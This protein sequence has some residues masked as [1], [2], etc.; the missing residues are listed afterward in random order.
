MIFTLKVCSENIMRVRQWILYLHIQIRNKNVTVVDFTQS[1][2]GIN[3]FFP[4]EKQDSRFCL[5]LDKRVISEI[6]RLVKE[7]GVKNCSEMKKHIEIWRKKN[8]SNVSSK[9]HR[10]NPTAAD[11]RN[12]I[13]LALC[14]RFASFLN[15]LLLIFH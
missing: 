8:I 5:P 7:D 10:F 6:R 11:I 13:F 3:I 4:I 1:E 12:H 2:I 15:H 9:S 14:D